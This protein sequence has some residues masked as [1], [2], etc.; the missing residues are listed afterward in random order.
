[1]PSVVAP[2]AF[3]AVLL[4]RPPSKSISPRAIMRTPISAAMRE[5]EPRLSRNLVS[6]KLTLATLRLQTYTHPYQ[7]QLQHSFG[8]CCSSLRTPSSPKK[9]GPRYQRL[10]AFQIKMTID[11]T[12]ISEECTLLLSAYQETMRLT[13][14]QTA[15]RIVKEDFNLSDSK[16]SYLL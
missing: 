5:L 7:T 11:I 1:M 6:R 14:S 12:N 2:K 3:K 8:S 9:S 15:T 10:S 4:T 13:D 16:N